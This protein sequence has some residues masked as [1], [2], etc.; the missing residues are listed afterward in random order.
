M[1]SELR[2]TLNEGKISITFDGECYNYKSY[3][4]Q[5]LKDAV[6]YAKLGKN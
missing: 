1:I 3:R 5:T 2:E 4:Y 6:A